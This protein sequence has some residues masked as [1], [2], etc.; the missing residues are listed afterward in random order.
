MTTKNKEKQ[1]RMTLQDCLANQSRLRELMQALIRENR[2]LSFNEKKEFYLLLP[3]ALLSQGSNEPVYL[4]VNNGWF[5][6]ASVQ[7]LGHRLADI[8]TNNVFL[9]T[10][11]PE[12][13]EVTLEIKELWQFLY[14]KILYLFPQANAEAIHISAESVERPQQGAYSFTSKEVMK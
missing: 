12:S 11:R 4:V 2:P 6:F 1:I 7:N 14:D 10:S 3:K 5:I 9:R 8:Y 13:V